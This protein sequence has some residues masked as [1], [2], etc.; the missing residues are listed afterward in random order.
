[1]ILSEVSVKRP[2]FATVISL[3]LMAFGLLSFQQIPIRELPD[4]DPP[5]VSINTDYP[6]ANAA[7]IETRV[8]Q[9]IENAI[10]GV[11]GIKL[12]ESTSRDGRSNIDIEFNLNRD[13]DAAANDVRD[14]ISRILDNLPE[15]VQPPEVSKADSD[16]RPIMYFNL[17]SPTMDTLQ[18]TDFAER[19]IVDRLSVVD[20][21]AAVRVS[22]ST[23]YAIRINLSRQAMAARGVTI[24]DVDAALRSE[25]VELPAGKIESIQRDTIVR[26]NREYT[27]PEEFAEIV[28]RVSKDT[29]QGQ[30]VRL[31]DIA[32]IELGG[33][34]ERQEFRG[35]G[36]PVVGVAIVKQST[37]N[38]VAVANGAA[39]PAGKHAAAGLVR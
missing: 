21:V 14:R 3:L 25:N 27:R 37:A 7:V 26:I 28:V 30:F 16:T 5:I 10:A 24:S 32:Q 23:R 6:G 17:I 8:T 2:V 36:N 13:I 15:E 29:G 9:L 31:G 39:N 18:L 20:G 22:G 4:V 19:N 12:I 1:M 11:A 38:T 34:R 35:N 33:E